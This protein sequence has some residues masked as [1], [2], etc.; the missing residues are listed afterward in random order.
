MNP[1]IH[2]P[3]TDEI[4]MEKN[5]IVPT[6]DPSL[7]GLWWPLPK[8]LTRN[9]ADTI[10]NM[11]ENDDTDALLDEIAQDGI[12]VKGGGGFDASGRHSTFRYDT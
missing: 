10:E 2:L 4:R 11:L 12:I 1:Y 6:V 9:T 5:K 7:N 8:I 3:N